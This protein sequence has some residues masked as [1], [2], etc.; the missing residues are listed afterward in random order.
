MKQLGSRINA[1]SDLRFET[2]SSFCN[3]ANNQQCLFFSSKS[4]LTIIRGGLKSLG[5]NSLKSIHDGG[6]RIVE[7]KQLCYASGIAWRKIVKMPARPSTNLD[8]NGTGVII[9]NN[10]LVDQC[11]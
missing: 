8:P 9:R 10:K 6:V 3:C 1:M 11:G 7:S 5:L 4:A 2:S